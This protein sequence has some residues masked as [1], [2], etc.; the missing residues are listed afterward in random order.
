MRWLRRS[1]PDLLRV[2]IGV[3]PDGAVVELDIKESAAAGLGP[4]GLCVGATGSGKSEFLRTLVLGMITAHPPELLNLVLVDFKGGAT[5]LGK[6]SQYQRLYF[7]CAR[8][9][10]HPYLG[11][12][13]RER[14]GRRPTT[15]GLPGPCRQTG[16]AGRQS[17]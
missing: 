16:V 14:S 1:A 10:L 12:P 8:R 4:H 5:F 9:H 6:K 7:F 3:A 15:R 2:P 13:G 11:R 17:L